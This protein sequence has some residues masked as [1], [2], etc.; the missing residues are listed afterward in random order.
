MFFFIIV[1]MNR[2][3]T[4]V[5]FFVVIIKHFDSEL[6]SIWPLRTSV[7]SHNDAPLLPLYQ[8]NVEQSCLSGNYY[9]N[10]KGWR[11]QRPRFVLP[12]ERSSSDTPPW[13]F[14]QTLIE[15]HKFLYTF[16]NN[17]FRNSTPWVQRK[18]SVIVTEGSNK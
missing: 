10:Y 1:N 6:R 16:C 7:Y 15:A 14:L 3:G 12:V 13:H 9:I 5:V 8:G 11:R 4:L 2:D 18:P 17:Y